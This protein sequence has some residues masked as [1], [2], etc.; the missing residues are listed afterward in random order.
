P[1]GAPRTNGRGRPPTDQERGARHLDPPAG[2]PRRSAPE[3]G[4]PRRPHDPPTN[5]HRGPN[6]LAD[7]AARPDLPA[8]GRRRSAPADV[9]PADRRRSAPA[10][11]RAADGHR[12]P[13]L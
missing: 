8:P 9:R 7:V 1:N 13:V 11:V 12:S 6:A 5:G 3:S 2:G 10:D 4:P